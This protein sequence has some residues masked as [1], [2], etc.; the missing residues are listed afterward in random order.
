VDNYKRLL[1]YLRHE[2]RSLVL[3]EPTRST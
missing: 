2:M 1:N 3:I